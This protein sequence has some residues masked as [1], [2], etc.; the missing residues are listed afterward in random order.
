MLAQ[1]LGSECRCQ[2]PGTDRKQSCA[3]DVGS[4]AATALRHN[5]SPV[6]RRA[7]L[8]WNFFATQHPPSR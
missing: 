8:G 4:F 5:S 3:A 7:A 1:K 2:Q 6:R